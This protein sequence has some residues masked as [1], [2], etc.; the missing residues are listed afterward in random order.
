MLFADLVGSTE[1][2]HRLDI[3]EY[4]ELL[5]AY[6]KAVSEVVVRFGGYLAHYLG[7][8]ILAY[9]GWP[10]AHDNEAERAVRAALAILDAIERMNRE[11]GGAN[12]LA[13]RIGVH[14]GAVVMGK[15]GGSGRQEVTAL[16]ETPNVAARVQ[17]VA[18]PNCILITPATHRLV[19][20]LFV[21]EDAGAHV[22]KGIAQPM[23]LR[24]VRRPSGVRSG[25][26]G[27][28]A[29]GLTLF[30]G[31]E[32]EL[33][34]IGDRWELAREGK[35][36]L[37]LISGEAGIGKSRLV[38]AFEDQIAEHPHTWLESGCGSI[39]ENT[40][41]YAVREMLK[42]GFALGGD[43]IDERIKAL[44]DSL[45]LA[46]LK[47]DQALPLVAPIL[48]LPIPDKYP[49][50]LAGPEEQ[51]RRLL[52]SLCSWAFGLARAQ[53]MVMVIEDL[54]WA[55]PS[56]LE[57]ARMLAEQG[58]TSKLLLVYTARPEFQAPWLTKTHHSHLA[59]N[60]LNTRQASDLIKHVASRIRLSDE[61]VKTLIERTAGVPLFLEELT[62]VVLEGESNGHERDIPATLH[63]SLVARLDRLGPAKEVAQVGAVI[64]RE[65]SYRLIEAVADL[66]SESLQAALNKLADAELLY[67]QGLPPDATYIFKHALVRDAAY[68]LL[69]K[70]R[71]RAI[72]Q[73][74]AGVLVEQFKDVAEAQPE[75]LAHHY[76][77]AGDAEQ[78]I[79]AWQ[80]AAEQAMS[81]GALK[82]A[83][84]HLR[85]AIAVLS[86]TAASAERSRRE[87]LLQLR[88][89][90]ILQATNGY[91]A[92]ETESAF[93]RARTLGEELGNPGQLVQ[94]LRGHFGTILM[95]GQTT[96]ARALADELHDAAQRDGN[97]ATLIVGHYDQGVSR[98]YRGQLS[99]ALPHFRKTVDLWKD[100]LDRTVPNDPGVEAHAYMAA[101]YVHLGM[102]DKAREEARTAVA[103]AERLKKP[104]DIA[105]IRHFSTSV[106][107]MLGDAVRARESGKLGVAECTQARIPHFAL[108]CG[109]FLGWAIA[110]QGDGAE[111][112]AMIRECITKLRA[113]GAMLEI[114]YYL[115]LLAQA[116][117]CSGEVNQALETVG[118]AV[119]IAPD[120]EIFQPYPLWVRGEVYV[121][122]GSEEE[123]EHALRETIVF[124]RG[125]GDRMGELRAATSLAR[126]LMLRGRPA[127]AREILSQA[128]TG[129]EEGFDTPHIAA[130]RDLLAHEREPR[131]A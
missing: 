84:G 19:S 107:V 63:D 67:L 89:G 18:P 121:R 5:R 90:Q 73:K 13:V 95:R 24:R 57:L 37:V 6:D 78:G 31:R 94:I 47:P 46:G 35:G 62:R 7:D 4:R 127:E 102:A 79:T 87:L 33:Q 66:S 17:A 131:L 34:L 100:D 64:G 56:T 52:A 9:F 32:H 53:P 123:A 25:L 96:A 86:A 43:S 82:E 98:F 92:P 21:V 26:Q 39:F 14:T 115:G 118:E 68:E 81:R 22:L 36:Q 114:N 93:T 124:S 77:Q 128:F 119:R 101:I 80:R 45:T 60:R 126:I 76:T 74:V 11:I 55:D 29:R 42:Q 23:E 48:E 28:A 108:T 2:S 105:F 69:L 129:F 12:P 15:V 65:F 54:H 112:V 59:L 71:R 58:A 40:P 85:S 20:G 1:L 16:G 120:Q 61:V 75:L 113:A 41:F 104:F 50:S 99:E 111:G 103:L 72:H 125:I 27:A 109:I 44:E 106:Q 83:E 70:S 116:Q 130:A 122:M 3:E 30:I 51:R 88:L 110:M 49:P 97:P 91:N 38:K 117:M 10:E 8:G